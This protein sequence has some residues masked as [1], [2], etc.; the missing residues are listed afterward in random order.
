MLGDVDVGVVCDNEARYPEHF[1]LWTWSVMSTHL[2][3]STY[4]L[5]SRHCPSIL[6]GFILVVF[7]IE[8]ILDGALLESEG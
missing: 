2:A 8:I 5:C 7:I 4:F 3:H 6:D 1:C